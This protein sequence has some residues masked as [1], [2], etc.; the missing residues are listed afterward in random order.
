M[1]AMK[2]DETYLS[3]NEAAK[4]LGITRQRVIQ[5]INKGR[6]K[7]SKFAKVYMIKQEDLKAVEVRVPGRPPKSSNGK[8]KSNKD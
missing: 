2:L 8:K 7:A 3:T 4:L 1:R 6:L 5:L